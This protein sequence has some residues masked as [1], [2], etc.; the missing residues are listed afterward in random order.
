[1]VKAIGLSGSS[2]HRETYMQLFLDSMIAVLGPLFLFLLL[3]PSVNAGCQFILA[4]FGRS[5]N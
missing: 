3:A 4:P 2:L 5:E 1:M